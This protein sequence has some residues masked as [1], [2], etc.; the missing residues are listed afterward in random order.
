MARGALVVVLL[1]VLGAGP[2]AA[3]PGNDIDGALADGRLMDAREIAARWI[4][5]APD[6]VNARYGAALVAYRSGRFDEARDHIDAGL[7]LL[8]GGYQLTGLAGLILLDEG[9]EE[10]AAGLVEGLDVD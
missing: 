2:A 9:D 5:D 4:A 8:P 7:R 1:L 10:G 6:D 3:A